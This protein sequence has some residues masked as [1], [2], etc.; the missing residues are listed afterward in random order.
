MKNSSQIVSTLLAISF[1]GAASASVSGAQGLY[2]KNYIVT[3]GGIQ[4]SVMDVYLKFN[5]S[6][7]TGSNGE[8]VVNFFGQAT[9]DAATY[10]VNKT[11][12]YEVSNGLAFQHSNT[13]WLPAA[14]AAGGTGNKTWDSFFTI[15]HSV[16][17]FFIS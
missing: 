13:S 11:A 2:A 6:S 17:V 5:S 4:Y 3:E 14:G 9:T 10:G 8:R 12:K 16:I 15:M 1:T 7:G